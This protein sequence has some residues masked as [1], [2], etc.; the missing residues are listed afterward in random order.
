MFLF[1]KT[2]A[3]RSVIYLHRHNN[4]LE[5]VVSRASS[6]IYVSST[7]ARHARTCHDSFKGLAKLEN[8]VEGTLFLLMWLSFAKFASLTRVFLP[9]F[10]NISLR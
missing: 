2:A 5:N 6:E 3:T 4:F 10:N 7:G 9:C 1:N 8:I